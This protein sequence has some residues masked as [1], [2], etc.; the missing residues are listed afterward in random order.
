MPAKFL[1]FLFFLRTCHSHL[2]AHRATTYMI[3]FYFM[4]YSNYIIIL[5]YSFFECHYFNT[6]RSSVLSIKDPMFFL[7]YF[8]YLLENSVHLVFWL[9]FDQLQFALNVILFIK[10][11]LWRCRLILFLSL[12]QLLLQSWHFLLSLYLI[13][14]FILFMFSWLWALLFFNY[15]KLNLFLGLYYYFI[16]FQADL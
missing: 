1:V 2:Y 16:A 11:Q 7:T 6:S 10:S 15:L 4:C 14:I 3:L 13:N 5:N 9:V 12:F 8:I